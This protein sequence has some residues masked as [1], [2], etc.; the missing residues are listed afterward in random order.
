MVDFITHKKGT[1]WGSFSG[2]KSFWT[3]CV[4]QAQDLLSNLQEYVNQMMTA[5]A[6][7]HCIS[8]QCLV[9][10]T[11]LL[12]SEAYNKGRVA[13]YTLFCPSKCTEP[14]GNT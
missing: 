10:H 5:K 6:M 4:K 3:F 12:F 1:T 9:S 13:F 7:I 14:A 8:T 2:F 11:E